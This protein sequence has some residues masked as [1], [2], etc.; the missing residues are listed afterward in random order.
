MTF[1]SSPGVPTGHD[2]P[3]AVNITGVLELGVSR[4]LG[5]KDPPRR[6]EGAGG[7]GFES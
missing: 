2:G 5:K 3:S 1:D 6:Q 4:A 7:A